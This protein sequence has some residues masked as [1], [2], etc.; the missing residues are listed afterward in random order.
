LRTLSGRYADFSKTTQDALVFS[1]KSL[2]LELTG[3]KRDQLMQAYLELKT[4]P[5]VP[6]ALR[7][8]KTAGLRLV[9][10]SN[11]TRD[12]LDAGI[13]NNGLDGMFEHVLSSDAVKAHKPDPRA[14]RVGR[15]RCE[16][17]RLSHL[18][19][20]STRPSARGTRRRSRRLGAGPHRSAEVHLADRAGVASFRSHG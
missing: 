2:Q 9:F 8:L 11:M 14:Y 19:G 17:L 16:D 20:Q 1:A 13:R 4:W 3:D 18:L 6:A 10:A 7:S 12:L 5:D 15:G